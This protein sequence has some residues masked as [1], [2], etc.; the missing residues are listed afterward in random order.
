MTVKDIAT[1]K[2]YVPTIDTAPYEK[3]WPHI[4]AANG[5]L[6][7]ELIGTE[8]YEKID[9]NNFPVILR[10]LCERVVALRAYERA[11]P[12]L[13]LRQTEQGFAVIATDGLVPASKERVQTLIAACRAEAAEA[14]DS[15][16]SF[17]ES[18][19]GEI[20][21][22]WLNSEVATFLTDTY[23]ATFKQFKRYMPHTHENENNI[24]TNRIE[25]MKLWGNMRNAIRSRIE[26]NISPELSKE[27][28]SQIN[29]KSIS[30][31]NEKIIEPVRF[32]LAAYTIG[33]IKKGNE[34]LSQA[35][36]ILEE[37]PDSYP[38]WKNSEVGNAVLNRINEKNDNR[39]YFAF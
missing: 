7:T 8:V 21:N 38:T 26:P 33:M 22:M 20:K 27:I 15:L 31:E 28:I 25:F 23:I 36:A 30:P 35:T 13:D 14:E 34:F 9:D 5:Y 16:L 11:I 19:S 4:N 1:F 18:I 6:E 24:P 12:F 39:I 29:T 2:K 17:L 3:I 10:E 37:N 32:A